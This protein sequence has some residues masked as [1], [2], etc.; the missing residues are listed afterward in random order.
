MKDN[1]KIEIGRVVLG[2]NGRDTGKHFIITK[3]VDNDYVEISDGKS[4]PLSKPKKKKVKHIAITGE[5][6]ETIAEKIKLDKK[7][8]DKELGSALR[9]YIENK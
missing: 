7:V 8:Y 5:V 4:R 2:K 3:V 9:Q 1:N 6:F